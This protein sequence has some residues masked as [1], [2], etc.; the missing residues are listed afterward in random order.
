MRLAEGLED[1]GGAS[2]LQEGVCTTHIWIG[3]PPSHMYSDGL[4]H[5]WQNLAQGCHCLRACSRIVQSFN[6]SARV[7]RDMC[8]EHRSLQ[9]WV[10]PHPKGIVEGD[11]KIAGVFPKHIL[12]K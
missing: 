7:A 3:C 8:D 12:E 9:M 5:I 4:G 10:V 1:V 11:D 6:A 2:R